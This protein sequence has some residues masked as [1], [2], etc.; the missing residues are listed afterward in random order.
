MP[1]TGVVQTGVSSEGGH[2]GY[3][4]EAT[5][6]KIMGEPQPRPFLECSTMSASDP[7]ERLV[8]EEG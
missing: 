1:A 5:V 2:I 4:G 6:C 8:F 7:Y 3:V